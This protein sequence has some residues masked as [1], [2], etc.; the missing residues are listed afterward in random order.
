MT[1]MKFLS[2]LFLGII[3]LTACS[4]TANHPNEITYVSDSSQGSEI[5]SYNIDKDET[6]NLS[7]TPAKLLG[8]I[9]R[10]AFWISAARKSTIFPK[11]PLRMAGPP[12]HPTGRKLPS[13]PI[14]MEHTTSS[15]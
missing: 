11:I 8:Q 1:A 4:S 5:F 3:L 10:F 7:N 15:L 9:M 6:L 12:G 13:P 14:G 2:T